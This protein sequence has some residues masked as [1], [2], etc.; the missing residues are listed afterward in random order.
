MAKKKK[1]DKAS[2]PASFA[3]EEFA[4]ESI[5]QQGSQKSRKKSGKEKKK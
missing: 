2:Q 5:P 1:I 4:S 3:T